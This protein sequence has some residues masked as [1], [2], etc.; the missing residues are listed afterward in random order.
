M[1]TEVPV[2]EFS[3]TN[4]FFAAWLLCGRAQ[5]HHHGMGF[6]RVERKDP[7]SRTK[8]FVFADPNN[9]GPLMEEEFGKNPPVRVITLKN[10]HQFLKDC[11]RA[12]D[13]TE[14]VK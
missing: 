4:H 2:P 8:L 13:Y 6:L 12:L 10:A 14:R 1:P 11:L 5:Y 9:Q 3:T 7:K